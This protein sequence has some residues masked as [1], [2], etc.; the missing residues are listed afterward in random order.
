MSDRYTS[1]G[2]LKNGME[3]RM[4]LMGIPVIQKS[5]GKWLHMI[6][7]QTR[8][9]EGEKTTAGIAYYITSAAQILIQMLAIFNCCASK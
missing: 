3:K 7:C 9:G 2:H 8:C 4:M 1:S 5:N 6:Y